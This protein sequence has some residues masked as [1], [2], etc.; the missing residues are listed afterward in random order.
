MT[1]SEERHED[2]ESGDGGD[3]QTR[4]RARDT[5]A[6]HPIGVV[7]SRTGVSSHTL[8]AW[9]KRYGAVEPDRTEGGHRLYSDEEIRRLRLLHRLTEQGHRIGQMAD[10]PTEELESLLERDRAARA[11]SRDRAGGENGLPV[12]LLDDLYSAVRDFD[13]R[14][15][16]SAFRRA[17][18]QLDVHRLINDVVAPMLRRIGE[19]WSQGDLSPAEEHLASGVVVRTLG[20]VMNNFDAG[21]DAPGVVTATPTGQRHNLGAM[22]AAATAAAAGWRVTYLGGELP[23]EEIV[24]AVRGTGAR[25]VAVSVVYPPDDQETEEALRTLVDRLPPETALL[26]GGRSVAS[27]RPVLEERGAAILEDFHDLRAVLEEIFP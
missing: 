24:R 12:E 18:L 15:L 13:G 25:A 6:R 5:V 21:P 2:A 22:L 4:H 1:T 10:L 11:P 7:E 17:A 14:R 19:E 3:P 8:R 16:D 23:A 26:A 9:E 27:Y 20:W